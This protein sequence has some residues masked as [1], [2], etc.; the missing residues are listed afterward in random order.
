MV[1]L[2]I[3]I[4]LGIG[5][6]IAT[7]F[8]TSRFIDGV[9]GTDTTRTLVT[10]A[11][12][13]IAL[14]FGTQL[15]SIVET[16]LAESLAWDTT[17]AIRLDLV[18]HVLALD[19][20]FHTS[21]SVGELIDRVDGDVSLLA[22]FLSR[23]VVVIVGNALL[24]LGVLV[25]LLLVDARIGL[26]LAGIVLVA[27]IV[28]TEIRKRATP[29]WRQERDASAAW[30]GELSEHL[31]GL[32]DIQTSNASG[33]VLRRNTLA[34][35]TLHRAFVQA[36]MMGYAMASS[37]TLLFGAGT[38][39]VLAIAVSQVGNQ[40]MTIGEIYLIYMYTLMLRNP[41]EQ[42]RNEIEDFQLADA[43]LQRVMQLLQERHGLED[44]G[45]TPFPTGSQPIMLSG[46]NFSWN[47]GTPVLNNINLT[48]APGKL[49]GIVG[50]TGSGKTTLTRL[51][52]RMIDPDDGTVHI[53]DVDLRDIP[54]DEIRQ[55]VGVMSQDV[56]IVH[57]TL[58]DNLTW[59]DDA[60]PDAVLTDV[61]VEVGLGDWLQSLPDGLETWLGHGGLSLS[62]GET[63]LLACTRILL[64]DP[65]I[66]ILDEASS[67]MDPATERVLQQAV[68]RVIRGRT[69][70]VIAHRLETVSAVDDIVVMAEG[71][72]LEHGSRQELLADPHSHFS[73]L[74]SHTI[75]EA[76]V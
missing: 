4:L 64:R 5:V 62:A 72:V 14:A 53:G 39:V 1:A 56:R 31:E 18:R 37:T 52:A 19:T 16:W 23:F 38:A 60:I 11:L 7:P 29:L 58:R 65:E 46:V 42:I 8:L 70:I 32:E 6:S 12:I 9:I 45:A 40:A 55:R 34:T 22:R 2:F 71:E 10:L 61:L 74:T 51:V 76:R 20:P 49:T 25:M 75:L 27:F 15:T 57:A 43:S 50:R 26:A 63:Q 28:F 13:T 35:R 59:F 54:L 24:I 44:T 66:V 67:R 73:R 47:P 48:F 3:V 68:S 30:Y 21:H 17:N 69:A 33:W 36:G 41:V